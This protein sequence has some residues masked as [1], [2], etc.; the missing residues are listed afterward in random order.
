MPRSAPQA[1]SETDAKTAGRRCTCPGLD[2]SYGWAPRAKSRERAWCREE[3][4][5]GVRRPVQRACARREEE[6]KAGEATGRHLTRE[7]TCRLSMVLLGPPAPRAEPATAGCHRRPNNFDDDLMRAKTSRLR[8]V[9]IHSSSSRLGRRVPTGC[10][11]AD[12][13]PEGVGAMFHQEHHG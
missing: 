11:A 7:G 1:I 5:E 13:E 12:R 9:S 4:R 3:V 10:Q 6:C 2:T 8:G